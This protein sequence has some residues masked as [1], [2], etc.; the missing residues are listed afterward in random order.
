MTQI[1]YELKLFN[2]SLYLHYPWIQV[3]IALHSPFR[4]CYPS[5]RR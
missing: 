5:I 4:K 3:L 1:S 2:L